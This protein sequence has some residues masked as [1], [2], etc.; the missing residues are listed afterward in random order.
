VSNLLVSRNVEPGSSHAGALGS[1]AAE[2]PTTV[3]GTLATL[4]RIVRVGIRLVDT[5]R[6]YA[7]GLDREFPV[8]R[9]AGRLRLLGSRTDTGE[10]TSRDR[11][12]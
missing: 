2:S 8:L 1:I 11:G 5:A 3:A 12:A 4:R 10:E 6:L 7:W 9:A